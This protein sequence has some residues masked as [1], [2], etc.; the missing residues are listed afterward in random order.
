MVGPPEAQISSES[1]Q[2]TILYFAPAENR[3]LAL[4]EGMLDLR[5]E[6]ASVVYVTDGRQCEEFLAASDWD[7]V[8][9]ADKHFTTTA[10]SATAHLAAGRGIVFL[11]TAD[12][13]ATEAAITLIPPSVEGPRDGDPPQP[14]MLPPIQAADV[15]KCVARYA[16]CSRDCIKNTR[17]LTPERVKCDV[18]C[19]WAFVGC[20]AQ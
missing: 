18:D 3:N 6:G 10:R 13:T 19:F 7:L 1:E 8:V 11:T 4:D 14:M 12:S 2:P 20:L 5:R 17:P 15:V 9:V 16:L